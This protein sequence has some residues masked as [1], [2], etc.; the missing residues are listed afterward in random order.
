MDVEEVLQHQFHHGHRTEIEAAKLKLRSLAV[1]DLI[2]EHAYLHAAHSQT[3]QI[4]KIRM[5]KKI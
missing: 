5:N 3:Y 2:T 1:I 4:L